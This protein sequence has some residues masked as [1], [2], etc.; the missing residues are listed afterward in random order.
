MQVY[1][2][3]V[4]I[5]LAFPA[6]A[7]G[8]LAAPVFSVA[9]APAPAGARPGLV[10]ISAAARALAEVS[11]MAAR[12]QLNLMVQSVGALGLS[13]QT[14]VPFNPT[15]AAVERLA[16]VPA[17]S[18]RPASAAQEQTPAPEVTAAAAAEPELA[19]AVPAKPSAAAG[20]L[21]YS[22]QLPGPASVNPA[23]VAYQQTASAPAAA[24]AAA[25]TVNVEA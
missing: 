1:S 20:E 8:R 10:Q 5:Q 12:P 19:P 23:V 16:P 14:F 7:A 13:A 11:P 4:I 3:Q 6:G 22:Q 18:E 17:V 24:V 25:A 21:V 2:S 15:I 9:S